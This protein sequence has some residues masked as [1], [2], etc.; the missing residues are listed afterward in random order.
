MPA[1]TAA[2]RNACRNKQLLMKLILC[3]FHHSI[4][5]WNHQWLF[6]DF[7]IFCWELCSHKQYY[8]LRQSPPVSQRPHS[9]HFLS[10]AWK[11]F[12]CTDWHS[13]VL[14]THEHWAINSTT[15]LYVFKLDKEYGDRLNFV[16]KKYTSGP[17]HRNQYWIP[18]TGS[19][20]VY[21]HCP[22]LI[23]WHVG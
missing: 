21:Q 22:I 2:I 17:A 5:V 1:E 14:V 10:E 19:Y 16:W 13:L 15:A 11:Q 7:V 9:A 6:W 18:G 3:I 20:L 12:F 8:G 23:Y 4:I